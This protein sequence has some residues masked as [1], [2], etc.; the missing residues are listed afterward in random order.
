MMAQ[1]R[2]YYQDVLKVLRELTIT[3]TTFG[4]FHSNN[5]KVAGSEKNR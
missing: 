2:Y 3:I 4:L 5:D 1:K